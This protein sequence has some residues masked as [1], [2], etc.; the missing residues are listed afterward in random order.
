M[1]EAIHAVEGEVPR[2]DLHFAVAQLVL[3]VQRDR[4]SELPQQRLL[5]TGSDDVIIPAARATGGMS[6]DDGIGFAIAVDVLARD[7]IERDFA[8]GKL[9]NSFSVLRRDRCPALPWLF[10]RGCDLG[11]ISAG[12]L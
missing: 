1:W 8:I 3:K 4:S 9:V 6:F 5:L 11:D 12:H 7:R 10:S 2:P